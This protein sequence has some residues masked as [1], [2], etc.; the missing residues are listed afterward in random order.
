MDKTSFRS[1]QYYDWILRGVETGF[2]E[3]YKK[4]Y[5]FYLALKWNVETERKIF[6]LTMEQMQPAFRILLVLHCGSILMFLLEVNM[7]LSYKLY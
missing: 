6:V 4:L 1:P 3:K 5:H 2:L 7:I